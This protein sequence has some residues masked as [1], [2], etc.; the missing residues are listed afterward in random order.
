MCCSRHLECRLSPRLPISIWQT[1][2]NC[3]GCGP[4][5]SL[6]GSTPRPLLP[7]SIPCVPCALA[8]GWCQ[9]TSSQRAYTKPPAWCGAHGGGHI[10]REPR[11]RLL[12][13]WAAAAGQ[14]DSHRMTSLWGSRRPRQRTP[15][16]E[17]P[18]SHRAL[19]CNSHPSSSPAC[20][21]HHSVSY[22]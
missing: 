14:S 18:S 4:R 1:S 12:I 13:G 10:F 19:P 20:L 3:S 2:P 15:L 8:A 7:S 5:G 9:A 11:V 16:R 22:L 17:A 6:V 21:L